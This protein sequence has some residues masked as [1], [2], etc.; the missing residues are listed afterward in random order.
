MARELGKVNGLWGDDRPSERSFAVQVVNLSDPVSQH[1]S[2]HS[3][4]TESQEYSLRESYMKQL[5]ACVLS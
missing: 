4:V 5:L 2:G 1:V 3:A